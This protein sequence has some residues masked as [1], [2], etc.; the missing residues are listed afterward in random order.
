M[1]A[2]AILMA[3]HRSEVVALARI[4]DDDHDYEIVCEIEIKYNK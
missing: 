1:R 4:Y 2:A 3:N